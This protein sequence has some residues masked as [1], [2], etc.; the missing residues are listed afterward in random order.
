M[1]QKKKIAYITNAPMDTE[2]A[3]EWLERQLVMLEK[4][5]HRNNFPNQTVAAAYMAGL[6]HAIVMTRYFEEF[7]A[8]PSVVSLDQFAA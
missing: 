8:D 2:K 6:Q 3:S 7:Q 1:A 4:M 5:Q